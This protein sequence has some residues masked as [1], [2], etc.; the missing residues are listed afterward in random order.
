MLPLLG[1]GGGPSV[2]AIPGAQMRR[3]SPRRRTEE[4]L[5]VRESLWTT[6]SLIQRAKVDRLQ[7]GK[8][9]ERKVSTLR[10][11]AR[12]S[13]LSTRCGASRSMGRPDSMASWPKRNDRESDSARRSPWRGCLRLWA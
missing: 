2:G 11:A 7:E 12:S 1:G 5:S 10:P 13:T 4:G 3:T 6:P 8:R 9:M